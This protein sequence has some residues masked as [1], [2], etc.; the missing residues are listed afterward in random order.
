MVDNK[1]Y[2]EETVEN[3]SNTVKQSENTSAEE[4]IQQIKGFSVRQKIYI[5]FGGLVFLTVLNMGYSLY[6]IKEVE[7]IGKSAIEHRQPAANL[8][9]QLTKDLNKS[10]TQLSTSLLLSSL[11]NP[12]FRYS[13]V[14]LGSVLSQER[15]IAT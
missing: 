7:E 15:W 1:K 13:P 5:G 2:S 12:D 3:L 14:C 4:N 9:Q 11:T 10:T 6:K 8:F